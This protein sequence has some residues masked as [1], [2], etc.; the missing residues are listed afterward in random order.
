MNGILAHGGTAGAAA[1]TVFVM[2]PIVIFAL[3]SRTSRLRREREDAEAAAAEV[4]PEAGT[5][6][7]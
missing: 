7:P 5:P 3:L 4:D 6:A 1:E 2:V